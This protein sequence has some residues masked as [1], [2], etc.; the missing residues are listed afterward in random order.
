MGLLD[1]AIREHLELKR[2]HGAPD[3]EVQRQAHEALGPIRRRGEPEPDPVVDPSVGAVPATSEPYPD[4]APAE[5]EIAA[6]GES[7]GIISP[8]PEMPP[9]EQPVMPEPPG[10]EPV[11]EDFQAADG[12]AAVPAATP[13][14]E[15]GPSFI[16]DE[17]WL[18]DSPETPPD[19]V[20]E[21]PGDTGASAAGTGEAVGQAP[22]EDDVLEET[23]DFLQE[24]P[25]HDRL[26]F[27]QRPPRGFDF[28]Q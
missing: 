19:D 12:P 22:G 28:E 16:D 7:T 3:E 20:L 25:E 10:H 27:E 1:D 5:A 23:P 2:R 9:T 17:P 15:R 24:T 11:I 6:A 13:E 18:D 8:P 21:P 4:E 14:A 26:W